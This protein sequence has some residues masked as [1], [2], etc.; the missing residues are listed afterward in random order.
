M[1]PPFH[2]AI[3]HCLAYL[4]PVNGLLGVAD[5]YVSGKHDLPLRQM[6]WARR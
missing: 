6:P 2:A 5:F 3:D 1:I 4:E